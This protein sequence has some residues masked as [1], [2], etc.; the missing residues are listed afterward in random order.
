MVLFFRLVFL[1]P[2]TLEIFIST[3]LM[4]VYC[5]ST[6]STPVFYLFAPGKIRFL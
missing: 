2:P 4:V 1:L 3:P 5:V 6:A